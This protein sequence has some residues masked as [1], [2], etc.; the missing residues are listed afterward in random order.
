MFYLGIRPE[1]LANFDQACWNLM[2][3]CWSAEPSQRPLLGYVQPQLQNIQARAALL[4]SSSSST[5][6][7]LTYS[8]SSP[9]IDDDYHYFNS[10]QRLLFREI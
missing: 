10:D 5:Q 1:C 2:E 4:V 7:K 9:S 3:M 8:C 6:G